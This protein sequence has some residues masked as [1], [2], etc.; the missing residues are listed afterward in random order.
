MTNAMTKSSFAPSSSKVPSACHLA[1]RIMGTS[2]VVSIFLFVIRLGVIFP[3]G[4]VR[5]CT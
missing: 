3:F 2:L 1:D 4:A 5:L